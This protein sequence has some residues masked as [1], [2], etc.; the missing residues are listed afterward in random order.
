MACGADR[1]DAL[2]LAAARAHVRPLLRLREQPCDA[3]RAQC[4]HPLDTPTRGFS[5]RL[6][7]QIVPD[8]FTAGT[9][10]VSERPCVARVGCSC[11]APYPAMGDGG[12]LCADGWPRP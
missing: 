3:E 4:I 5:R 6:S 12:T 10:D 9:A 2:C 7:L 8:L 1:A 11:S